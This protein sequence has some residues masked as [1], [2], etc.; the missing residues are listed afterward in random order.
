MESGMNHR[1]WIRVLAILVFAAPAWAQE[2]TAPGPTIRLD[3]PGAERA[4]M[5]WPVTA[6]LPFAREPGIDLDKARLVND[7]GQAVPFQWRVLQNWYPERTPRWVSL[8]YQADPRD[9]VYRLVPGG[10]AA[11]TQGGATLTDGPDAI[12]A[13]TGPLRVQIPKRLGGGIFGRVW[14]DGRLVCENGPDAGGYL[15]DQNGV[16]FLASNDTTNYR[17][18]VE[19]S[20]PLHAVVRADGRY[21]AQ[22]GKAACA[23]TARLHF[24][25]GKTFVR[26][27]HTFLFTENS[28]DLQIRDLGVRVSLAPGI[29]PATAEFDASAA[30]DERSRKIRLDPGIRSAS[31]VQDV[32]YHLQQPA[33]HWGMYVTGKDGKDREILSGKQ[34]G[35]WCALAGD[36]AGVIVVLK[37]FW[38]QFPKE[39]EVRGTSVVAHL[40]SSTRRGPLDFRIPAV[41][42]FWGEQNLELWRSERLYILDHLKDGRFK[43]NA[44]G[45]AKTHELLYYFHAPE[46]KTPEV[47]RHFSRPP[48]AYPD[49]AWTAATD[50]AGLLSPRDPKRYPA[51]EKALD[52]QV[53]ELGR[54]VKDWGNY[55]WW[56]HGAGPHLVYRMINGKPF[57]H[58]K[59]YAGGVEYW[60][61][62]A[63]WKGYLRSGDR[64]YFDLAAPHA[65]HFMDVVICHLDTDTRW[66]GDFFNIPG[67]TPIH[68]G[69]AKYIEMIKTPTAGVHAQF[70]WT[71]DSLLYYYYLTGDDR[72]WDVVQEYAELHKR[73]LNYPEWVDDTLKA[74]N[75][76]W[77]RKVFATLD[78]LSI[79]YEATGDEAFRRLA[80][81][82]ARR[83]LIPDLPGGI[84]REPQFRGGKE[85]YPEPYA[86]YYKT[87]CVVRYHRATGDPLGKQTVLRMVQYDY[88]TAHWSS[89]FA[90]VRYAYAWLYG[91]PSS[92][93][94]AGRHGTKVFWQ[95]RF[96]PWP[97][98]IPY[99]I[100]PGALTL[101]SGALLLSFNAQMAA[102]RKLG[103]PIQPFPALSRYAES[104]AGEIVVL[105][106]RGK[107]ARLEVQIGAR[108]LHV[109]PPGAEVSATQYHKG[110]FHQVTI[111]AAAPAGPYR[112]DA[113]ARAQVH[114]LT[115][116]GARLA[117]HAPQGFP[118][119]AEEI[120]G[121]WF[122]RAPQRA[123]D[124]A[125]ECADPE[126]VTIRSPAGRDIR[127]NAGQIGSERIP[128][129]ATERAGVWSLSS[130][131]RTFVR[132]DGVRP[133]FA[134]RDKQ[135]LFPA[136]GLA[137][138]ASARGSKA[139]ER[140]PK[141]IS[142]KG[143]HIG[144]AEHL[145]I[146]AG[147]AINPQVRE[148]FNAVEG[149]VEFWFR[150]D[151]PYF[152]SPRNLP[153]TM[154][155]VPD[156]KGEG[157]VFNMY[158]LRVKRT[159]GPM[160]YDIRGG[161]RGAEATV[162]M[163][164]RKF[165][166][167]M[168]GEWVH[169]A[170]QWGT[171]KGRIFTL[172][173][174]VNGRLDENKSHRLRARRIRGFQ[175]LAIGDRILIGGGAARGASLNGILDELRISNA[176]RYSGQS[177]APPKRLDADEHTLALF[178]F[179]SSL[180]AERGPK[181]KRALQ[182]R[183]GKTT[184]AK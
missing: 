126:L 49:P 87:P 141:G 99:Q 146:P 47:A 165:A 157:P 52:V 80:K 14:L 30:H 169:V 108:E 68:W 44:K 45:L 84:H 60:Y 172:Q 109:T 106:E 133:L 6:G 74:A 137:T 179:E 175:P 88:E 41:L 25:A 24:Y 70:G 29:Q 181:G 131:D 78:E 117:L 174:Y 132:I 113:P 59:R 91:G 54:F 128:V 159:A 127:L 50:V 90:G 148:N 36:N 115:C 48:L 122:F 22:D 94:A 158:Y 62:R 147:R 31:L 83:I 118:V 138:I 34:A 18:R 93:L 43:S 183:I 7:R 71:V 104:P 96:T 81:Q 119:E 110:S 162:G 75:I 89:R 164:G 154:L 61:T 72:A 37:N 101:G 156:L 161:V 142:G 17:V 20:G 35:N 168:P 143:L 170:I 46:D 123:R 66:R 173:Y 178:R 69:G 92:Y 102:E 56:E 9:R 21:V 97:P 58:P 124:F 39:L 129:R 82:L 12:E 67:Q 152:L 103:R 145:V 184:G 26:L 176:R 120:S 114:V 107:E 57:G 155:L 8:E 100:T 85:L 5:T 79:L 130:K 182:G 167:W 171:Q 64:R 73:L 38:Q 55:G 51:E 177:V 10:R 1:R 151:W 98:G 111:P 95:R 28:N 2:Q 63:L 105:K 11:R 149:T 53:E 116:T 139:G 23:Y 42:E 15:V 134:F 76:M 140:Y 32:Y 160:A 136:E 4:T 16:L 77:S 3:W 153:R 125:V 166:R 144:R 112:I 180:A 163:W 121:R 33:S 86:L 13:D 150:P 40:W 65:R 27:Q 135:Q 19:R